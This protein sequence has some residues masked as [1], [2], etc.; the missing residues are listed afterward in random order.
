MPDAVADLP[1]IPEGE[2]GPELRAIYAELKATAGT[3]M[4]NLVYRHIATIPDALPWA[5]TTIRS[6]IGHD[7]IGP[8]AD[9]LAKPSFGRPLPAAA[10]RML[11][12]ADDDVRAAARVVAAYNVANALNLVTLMALRR[13]MDQVG[14][15]PA[16]PFA[17]R[18]LGGA[19]GGNSAPD[20]P[21]I[22]PPSA[23]APETLALVRRLS[24]VGDDGADGAGILP[25]LYRHLGHWP[26]HLALALAVLEP[27]DAAGAIRS[28]RERVTASASDAAAPL[29][30]AA[31]S[32]GLD[33]VPTHA[34]RPLAAALDTF[35]R[36][37]IPR[38]LP[39]GHTLLALTP[40]EL[41]PPEAAR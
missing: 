2:A 13:I 21:P 31:L 23:M 32:A 41:R 22:P 26:G 40:S 4:V 39:I 7:R 17:P 29:V 18:A 1:E 38:M 35:T 10:F 27:L 6:G 34:R 11:G 28:A 20:L 14:D 33:P 5:W 36:R 30:A 15:G 19:A 37:V 12:L 16:A 3:A 9:R 25:S 8:A 24:R